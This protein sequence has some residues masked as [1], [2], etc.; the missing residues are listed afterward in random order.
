[1]G[2]PILP[3][4]TQDHYQFYQSDGSTT[5]GSAD[6]QQSLDVDTTY[7]VAVT[8]SDTTAN[9]IYN[10][11]VQWQ[12]NLAGAGWTAVGT[13]TAVKYANGS[14]TDGDT[15]Q[16][17]ST[18]AGLGT[19]RGSR[20]YESEN[21]TAVIW[22]TPG[23]ETD[24][25]GEAWLGFT[26]D[27]AQ[28]SNGQEILLRCVEGNDTVFTGTY[29]N[30]DIDVVE[31]VVIQGDASITL[32]ALTLSSDGDIAIQGDAG[33]TLAALTLSSDGSV[34]IVGDSGITLGSLTLS[35]DGT[36]IAGGDADITL[37]ALTLSADGSITDTVLGNANIILAAMV[38]SSDGTVDVQGA[39]SVTLGELLLSSVGKVDIAGDS[40]ITLDDLTLVSAG[41]VLLTGDAAIT[42][43]DLTLSS[44]GNSSGNIT[45]DADIILGELGLSGTGAIAVQGDSAITLGALTLTG[46]GGEAAVPNERKGRGMLK[47]IGRGMN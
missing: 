26:I 17:S 8:I 38:L 41:V 39:L 22:S 24:N 37:A 23:D 5:V 30:A 14:L 21:D 9:D 1:M 28:V 27:S 15:T 12:Y 7:Y 11:T 25:H 35:A 43:E 19:F 47:N 32:A 2:M 31:E 42:L 10:L 4:W 16:N 18:I 45:G 13:T 33:I 46:Q 40:A 34:A 44:T 6:T 20:V 29:T 36:A 3:T